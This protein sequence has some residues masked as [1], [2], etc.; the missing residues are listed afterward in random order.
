MIIPSILF[1]L[2]LFPQQPA[3]QGVPA[4]AQ[5]LE[6]GSVIAWTWSDSEGIPHY[7]VSLDKGETWGRTRET[8]YDIMLR[9]SEFD[10]VV[11]GA[12]SVP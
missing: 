9:Y 3:P 12:P 4:D 1:S 6:H 7:K 11:D 8:S 5:H 10:P 2:F